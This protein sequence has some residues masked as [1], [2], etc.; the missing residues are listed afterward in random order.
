MAGGEGMRQ[1]GEEEYCYNNSESFS[2][3]RDYLPLRPGKEK[4]DYIKKK[5]Q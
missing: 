1:I 5:I 2:M 3:N 4:E